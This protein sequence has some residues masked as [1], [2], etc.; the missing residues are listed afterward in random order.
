MISCLISLFCRFHSLRKLIHLIFHLST[1][2]SVIMRRI[3]RLFWCW[4]IRVS[5]ICRW[6][7]WLNQCLVLFFPECQIKEKWISF[8]YSFW[9]VLWW[10]I[11]HK[12]SI[13]FK[14]PDALTAFK[15]EKANIFLLAKLIL[16]FLA[17]LRIKEK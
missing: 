8:C 10:I 16:A 3:D 17:S 12:S 7:S 15:P 4:W 1:D 9:F 2:L 14:I 6:I 13:S 5:C 11:T